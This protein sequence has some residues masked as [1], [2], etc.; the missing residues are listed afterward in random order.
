MG[1]WCNALIRVSARAPNRLRAFRRLDC[2]DAEA[3]DDVE[4]TLLVLE[5]FRMR[6][7]LVLRTLP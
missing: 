6:C 3:L 2:R 7:K 4:A 5:L 1:N